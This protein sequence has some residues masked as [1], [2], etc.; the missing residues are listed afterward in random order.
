MYVISGLRL[1]TREALHGIHTFR[2]YKGPAI[3]QRKAGNIAT[4][5]QVIFES[6][7]P[8]SG[9]MEDTASTDIEAA[10][11]EGHESCSMVAATKIES[12]IKRLKNY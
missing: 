4:R 10:A 6:I 5:E 1:I 3:C 11:S 8:A 7:L 9:D 12:F 2:W